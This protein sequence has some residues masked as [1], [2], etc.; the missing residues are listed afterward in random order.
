M[1]ARPHH[2]HDHRIGNS[3]RIA[4]RLGPWF[5]G[6]HIADYG[7]AAEPVSWRLPA[8]MFQRNSNQP[9]PFDELQCH[10]PGTPSAEPQHFPRCLGLFRNPATGLHF[11]AEQFAVSEILERL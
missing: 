1:S 8:M 11:E 4:H 3:E 2:G 6:G 10:S 5:D 7:A 9:A